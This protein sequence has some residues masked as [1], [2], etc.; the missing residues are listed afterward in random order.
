MIRRNFLIVI[1]GAVFALPTF[2]SM[3]AKAYSC[4]QL[5]IALENAYNKFQA[6]DERGDE[7]GMYKYYVA[8]NTIMAQGQ[9]Q[10]CK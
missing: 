4:G 1:F 7:A 3:P 2:S 8:F 9:K 10:G 6:A 5:L